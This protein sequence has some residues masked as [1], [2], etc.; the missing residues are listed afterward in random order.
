VII[1]LTAIR[2][3]TRFL[4]FNAVKGCADHA[5]AGSQRAAMNLLMPEE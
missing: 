2:P 3:E 4:G 5:Q 1:L